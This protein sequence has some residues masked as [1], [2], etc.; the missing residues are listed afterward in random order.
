MQGG[1]ASQ[2]RM[3]DFYVPITL[4]DSLQGRVGCMRSPRLRLSILLIVTPNCF[5]KPAFRYFLQSV[6]LY[7]ESAG[8]CHTNPL[9]YLNSKRC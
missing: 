9:E 6:W 5:C 3:I 8:L 2:W 7:E 4:I 1:C